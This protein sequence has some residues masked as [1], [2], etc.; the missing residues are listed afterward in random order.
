MLAEAPAG[1]R[2]GADR[3]TRQPA[4]NLA[5]AA[6]DAAGALSEAQGVTS[7][8]TPPKACTPLPLPTAA[9]P[10]LVKAIFS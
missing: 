7:F 6:Q 1:G 5:P 3:R 9:N 8:H 10:V 4:G 2:R